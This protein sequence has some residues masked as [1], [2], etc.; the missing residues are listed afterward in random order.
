MGN[1]G[2]PNT[3][4]LDELGLKKNVESDR[5]QVNYAARTVL[6][7]LRSCVLFL[8]NAQTDKNKCKYIFSPYMQSRLF[9]SMYLLLEGV[10]IAGSGLQCRV[11]SLELCKITGTV[12]SGGEGVYPFILL[13]LINIL[14]S[15]YYYLLFTLR[16]R[17]FLG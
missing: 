15:T 8:G 11:Q 2:V 16:C 6:A 17:H 12:A 1:Y 5:I 14:T 4:E 10:R 3:Q 7:M 9:V 13:L